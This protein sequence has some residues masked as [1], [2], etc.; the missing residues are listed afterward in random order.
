MDRQVSVYCGYSVKAFRPVD[1]TS[2]VLIGF[3]RQG[4]QM[5]SLVDC[6]NEC[7]LRIDFVPC[8]KKEKKERRVGSETSST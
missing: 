5:T 4:T 7:W 8:R 1:G 3:C 2:E 6:V